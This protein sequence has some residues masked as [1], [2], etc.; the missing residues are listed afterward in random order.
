MKSFRTATFIAGFGLAGLLGAHRVGD[1]MDKAY[2][3]LPIVEI[4][5]PVFYKSFADY[6]I[7]SDPTPVNFIDSTRLESMMDSSSN[8]VPLPEFIS[9]KYVLKK[10]ENESSNNAYAISIHDAR[11]LMQLKKIAWEQVDTSDYEN[12]W[13]KPR[14]SMNAGRKYLR[15]LYNFLDINYKVFGEDN[16]VIRFDDLNDTLKLDL[17]SAAYNV[18]PTALMNAEWNIVSLDDAVEYVNKMHIAMY[19]DSSYGRTQFI[20][21]SLNQDFPRQYKFL[22]DTSSADTALDYT[23]IDSTMSR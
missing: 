5:A 16:T 17:I 12:N 21:D 23:F 13:Y 14:A 2:Q 3:K 9:S 15:Y 20:G 4:G 8:E 11:G 10:I 19:N 1:G 22:A 18:G 6:I 7:K